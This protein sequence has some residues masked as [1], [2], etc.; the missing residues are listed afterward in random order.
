MNRLIQFKGKRTDT[1]EYVVGFFFGRSPSDE[2]ISFVGFTNNS[3]H[4]VWTDSMGEFCGFELPNK[5]KLFE[6]D[7]VSY[8][9]RDNHLNTNFNAVIEFNNGCFGLQN[10]SGGYEGI[11][12]PFSD[13]HEPE[14]Y[15]L[16]YLTV[17]G[18]DFDDR[19]RH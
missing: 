18:T 5:T 11:F 10:I 9:N 8:D 3:K 1:G 17:I 4:K 16:P 12:T 7:I 6:G 14:K 2:R 13:F 15:L 19:F